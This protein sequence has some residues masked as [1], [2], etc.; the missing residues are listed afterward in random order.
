MKI[1]L[2]KVKEKITKIPTENL[3]IALIGRIKSK[4]VS[5]DSYI[6]EGEQPYYY[7]VVKKEDNYNDVFNNCVYNFRNEEENYT[8]LKM[9]K[10][11]VKDISVTLDTLKEKLTDYNDIL[12]EEINKS[13]K[14][15]CFV[16][17]RVN[18]YRK[19]V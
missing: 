2:H 19:S 17:T 5:N 18:N 14:N 10:Y 12:E 11:P 8:I 1:K 9:I 13:N 4:I 16:R 6:N 15:K 3:Y 7:T